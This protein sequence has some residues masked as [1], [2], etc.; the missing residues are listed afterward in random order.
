MKKIERR[1]K[2]KTR[3]EIRG[4]MEYYFSLNDYIFVTRKYTQK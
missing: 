3:K 2:R 1:T 4:R